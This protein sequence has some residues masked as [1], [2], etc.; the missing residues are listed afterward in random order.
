MGAAAGPSVYKSTTVLQPSVALSF[1][2][3]KERK[4]EEEEEERV[5]TL[6]PAQWRRLFISRSQRAILKAHSRSWWMRPSKSGALGSSGVIVFPPLL[7]LSLP[8]PRLDET[9]GTRGRTIDSFPLRRLSPRYRYS[10]RDSS[11]IVCLWRTAGSRESDLSPRQWEERNSGGLFLRGW[12]GTT[13]SSFSNL[14]ARNGE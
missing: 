9:L 4:E 5:S 6:P 13:V 7:A 14:R 1:A 8:C 2:R 11:E 12:N 10:A 3:K